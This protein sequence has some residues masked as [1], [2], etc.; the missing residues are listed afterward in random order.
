MVVLGM[1]GEAG[2]LKERLIGSTAVSVGREFKVPV[3]IV[4]EGAGYRRIHRISLA[5]DVDKLEE[6][7]LLLCSAHYFETLFDAELEIVT[8]QKP[9]EGTQWR[10]P[11]SYSFN[12]RKIGK[13]KHRQVFVRD[14]DAATALEYYFK[15][16]HTDLIMANPKKHS[17]FERLFSESVTKHLAF[18]SRVP[19]LLIH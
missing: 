7:T 2:K 4:P 3:L 8:V 17:F 1:T 12:E 6:S 18:H 19:L 14:N 9:E 10:A 15:F 13:T 16:H 5:C 11:E